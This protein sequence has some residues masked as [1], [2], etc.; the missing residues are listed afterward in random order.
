M[1]GHEGKIE[2]VT[3]MLRLHNA[4]G[5]NNQVWVPSIK[6]TIKSLYLSHQG[7]DG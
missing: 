6:A 4:L 3:S 2:L 5:Q 1:P 7:N